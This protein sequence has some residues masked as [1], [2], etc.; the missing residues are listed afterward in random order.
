MAKYSK[1]DQARRAWTRILKRNGQSTRGV[2]WLAAGIRCFQV[3]VYN[4]SVRFGKSWSAQCTR[5]CK[6]A[7][8]MPKAT[9]EINKSNLEYPPNEQI[10]ENSMTR[11]SKYMYTSENTWKN[12]M[13]KNVIRKNL[14]WEVRPSP[15]YLHRKD[16]CW[17]FRREVIS[18]S[19][20]RSKWIQA[21]TTLQLEG[22]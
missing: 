14:P 20:R 7:N 15:D 19:T 12:Q 8:R 21:L 16:C 9:G 18:L 3:A 13:Q 1:L 6:Q 10:F 17:I 4:S 11:N 2:A 22:E 5:H